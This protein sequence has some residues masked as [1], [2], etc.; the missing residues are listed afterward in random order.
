MRIIRPPVVS[1]IVIV[2]G[3]PEMLFIGVA[4]GTMVEA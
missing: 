1:E 2:S 4:L 3:L